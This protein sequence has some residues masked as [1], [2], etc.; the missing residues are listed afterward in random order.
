MAGMVGAERAA[1]MK[2]A[3]WILGAL[4]FLGLGWEGLLYFHKKREEPVRSSGKGTQYLYDHLIPNLPEAV[5]FGFPLRPPDGEG[6]YLRQSFGENEEVGETWS[7]EPGQA[8]GAE[9]VL[10]CA[11][12]LVLLAENLMSDW[13]HVVIVV[14]RMPSGSPQSAVETL[15]AG[16]G[17]VKVVAGDRVQ[18]GQ[19][20]GSLPA[21]PGAALRLEVRTQAGMGLGPGAAANPEGWTAPTPFIRA[22]RK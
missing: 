11:D 21:E 6:T 20:L 3:L 4:L 18:R 13:G 8:R 7:V 9:P 19:W 22:R 10:A 2:P 1:I 15:Y 17:D 16:L 12:G 14:H 5:V